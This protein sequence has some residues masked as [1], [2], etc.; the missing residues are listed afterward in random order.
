MDVIP[1]CEPVFCSMRGLKLNVV[2][3]GVQVVL[4]GG[5]LLLA[6]G[7]VLLVWELAT[8]MLSPVSGLE[9]QNLLGFAAWPGT[10][11]RPSAGLLASTPSRAP[12][13][14]RLRLN[15]L[16]NREQSPAV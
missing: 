1:A 2:Y 15:N 3:F 11:G 8:G 14:W 4:A 9:A 10:I 6:A 5:T 16:A 13:S 12:P 7:L